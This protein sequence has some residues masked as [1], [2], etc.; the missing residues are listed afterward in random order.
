[1]SI[2]GAILGD[3]IGQ[4]LGQ[5][6][7]TFQSDSTRRDDALDSLRYALGAQQ[8]NQNSQL[9]QYQGLQGLSQAAQLSRHFD[10]ADH[11]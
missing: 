1:M 10:Q 9:S 6:G 8:A 4:G 7:Q 11:H 3:M 5:A 2:L